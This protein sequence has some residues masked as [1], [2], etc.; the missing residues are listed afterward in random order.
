MTQE[1]GAIRALSVSS[2]RLLFSVFSWL[3]V[4]LSAKHGTFRETAAQTASGK[5]MSAMGR[6]IKWR[7][8]SFA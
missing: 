7:R 1:N 6:P 4:R 2:V 3:Q 8:L 5:E